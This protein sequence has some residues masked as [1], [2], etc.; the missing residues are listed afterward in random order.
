MVRFFLDLLSFNDLTMFVVPVDDF[1][2][3]PHIRSVIV[4]DDVDN[5][6]DMDLDDES[7]EHIYSND[8][9]EGKVSDG[10]GKLV[11]PSYARVVGTG[12]HG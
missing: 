4:L 9:G 8:D 10:V 6:H 7:W 5:V 3:I 11:E 12:C 1:E 2:V